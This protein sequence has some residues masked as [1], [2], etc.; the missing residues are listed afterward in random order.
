MF[1]C[2]IYTNCV[3]DLQTFV[4]SIAT[5]PMRMNAVGLLSKGNT[6]WMLAAARLAWPGAL[7]VTNVQRKALQN[8]PNSV[9]GAQ[10]SHIEVTLSMDDP[11]SKVLYRATQTVVV[12][13]A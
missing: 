7:N 1:R 8:M 12:L 3:S 5:S 2:H 4:P 11:S 10:A 6:V 9:L 13:V